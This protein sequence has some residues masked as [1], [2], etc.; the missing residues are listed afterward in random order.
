[1]RLIQDDERSSPGLWPSKQS[2]VTRILNAP[3]GNIVAATCCRAVPCRVFDLPVFI[4]FVTLCK[5][6]DV[7]VLC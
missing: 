3:L 5:V 1:M 7:F 6:F 4:M 2:F